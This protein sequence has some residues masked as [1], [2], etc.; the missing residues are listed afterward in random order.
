[1]FLLSGFL[2]CHAVG[3][4]IELKN[5]KFWWRI[6]ERKILISGYPK[7]LKVFQNP[8]VIYATTRVNSFTIF[9][10]SLFYCRQNFCQVNRQFFR[11]TS[12]R[13]HVVEGNMLSPGQRKIVIRSTQPDNRKCVEVENRCFFPL[14][15]Y[16]YGN[17]LIF[18]CNTKHSS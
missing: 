6:P 17:Y 9:L 13:Q 18:F 3:W 7:D 12:W 10:L 4:Y 8:H 15:Y 1:M 11:R 14:L 2:I 16:I 5:Q